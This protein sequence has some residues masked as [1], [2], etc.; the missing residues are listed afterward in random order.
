M[1]STVANLGKMYVKNSG[2]WSHKSRGEVFLKQSG[3]QEALDNVFLKNAGTWYPMFPMIALSR[4]GI[5][6]FA[7]SDLLQNGASSVQDFADTHLTN[8]L[9]SNDEGITFDLPATS[10][11]TYGYFATPTLL[12][13]AEF[14][15]DDNPA[16]PGGWDGA[17]WSSD[18]WSDGTWENKGPTTV[19]FDGGRGVEDWYVYRQDN[20]ELPAMT[21]RI[22][23]PSR[24]AGS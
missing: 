8:I 1:P 2:A 23:W 21:W 22:N 13:E 9:A 20:P 14:R 6:T 3:V 15:D 12:G 5:T 24:P 4:W 16:F 7:G 19:Q 11:T 10:A 18:P 17:T